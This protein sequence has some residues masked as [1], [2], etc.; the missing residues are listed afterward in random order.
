[1]GV[2]AEIAFMPVSEN[3]NGVSR[4]R[5]ACRRGGWKGRSCVVG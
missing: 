2:A 1:M 4:Q 3:K 5:L